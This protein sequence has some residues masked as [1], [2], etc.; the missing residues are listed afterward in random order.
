MKWFIFGTLS[1]LIH[2]SAF[3][4]PFT[5]DNPLQKE[6]SAIEVRIVE[7]SPPI[8]QEQDGENKTLIAS[9]SEKDVK[10]H[11]RI[12]PLQEK[13]NIQ[14]ELFP[15]DIS[16]SFSEEEK[17]KMELKTLPQQ[18]ASSI[19]AEAVDNLVEAAYGEKLLLYLQEIKERLET[20][21]RYPLKAK[22]EGVEGTFFVSFTL[23]YN[24]ETQAIKLEKSSGHQILD[25]EAS[26]IVERAS[27]FPPF[28]QDILKK[29]L[30]ITFPVTFRI[31]H[32]RD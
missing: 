18:D 7:A 32:D 30:I 20:C 15:R 25:Q 26:A 29:K 3:L 4:Y 12:I 19:E 6:A 17:A 21:K 9:L 2:L 13:S 11:D 28:P 16:D 14:E 10:E 22:R 1:S 31:D 5:I 8:Q 27:P 24:G 23:L